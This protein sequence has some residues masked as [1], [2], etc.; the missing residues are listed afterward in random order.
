[1]SPNPS[2]VAAGAAIA[3]TGKYNPVSN[4][5]EI[6]MP[7][8]PA[9]DDPGPGPDDA[10]HQAAAAE[11]EAT[12]SKQQ[13]RSVSA[14]LV[15]L[16]MAH[17][18]LG[19]SDTDEPYAVANTRPHI[20]LPL[21]GGK[22]G[23]RPELARRYYD[24]HDTVPGSQAL[25][26]AC[27]VLEGKAAQADPQPI[28]LRVAEAGGVAYVDLGGPDCRVIRITGGAWEIV[29][30]AP[31]LFRRTKLTGVMVD[32]ERGGALADLWRFALINEADRPVVLAAM[33]QALIQPHTPHPVLGLMGEQ[34]LTK[35][36][37]SRVLVDLIDPSSVPLRQ[38]PRDP[39]SWSTAASASWVVGLDNLS[40][41]SAWLSDSLCRAVTGDGLVKRAL[42][43]DGDVS[44]T[45]F[46]RCVII[47]GIDVGAMRGD[48]AER[49]AL[50][51]LA[52]LHPD[53][54]KTEEELA[55]AWAQQR[56]AIFGALLDLAARVHRRLPDVKVQRPPRMAD[57]A[58]VLAAVDAEL[59]T[60]GLARYRER[61]GRLAADSLTA[62][63][64]I[65]RLLAQRH[66]CDGDTAAQILDELTPLG[67]EWRK[68]KD[69][70][71]NARAV[72]TLLKRHA[73]AMRQ[74]G[75]NVWDDGGKNKSNVARWTIHPPTLDQG[76]ESTSRSS[77]TSSP[78]VNGHKYG[79]VSGE[80]HTSPRPTGEVGE[81]R[82]RNGNSDTSPNLPP[83]NW[84]DELASKASHES[85]S[86][87]LTSADCPVCSFPITPGMDVN[88]RHLD[89]SSKQTTTTREEL[90]A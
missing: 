70:P 1:M 17:Y 29:D 24:Q 11:P 51:D 18:A 52:P 6:P 89:C 9:D 64:F 39:E 56:P 83:L 3:A 22:T 12:E 60:D 16:T 8:E 88:G 37:T 77:P 49:V 19:I 41:I 87:P 69:W 2:V 82:A 38:P 30:T 72:T 10:E 46:R 28:H 13:R 43:T 58:R 63:E 50:A 47:N 54:R 36:S 61:A 79:E 14:Q 76:S 84:D 85:A 32:P 65:S 67:K 62:D 42:Y 21:R 81:E 75:W 5:D 34:G 73:P 53:H 68:P 4:R 80:V 78:Q 59:G 57:F 90:I 7:P 35:S 15:D 44:V 55:E 48:L 86:A 71:K 45:R 25:T 27:T 31:V 66:S 23:Y 26:D 40:D 74:L 20:A 33:V